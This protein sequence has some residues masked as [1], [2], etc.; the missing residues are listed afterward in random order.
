MPRLE[1]RV[2]SHCWRAMVRLSTIRAQTGL[3][4]IAHLMPV[5][6]ALRVSRRSGV[7][8]YK[9]MGDRGSL[10]QHG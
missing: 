2:V 6:V 4:E 7:D 8:N 1:L 3:D 9:V 10:G 5:F